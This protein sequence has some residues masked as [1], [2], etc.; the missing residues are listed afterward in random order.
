MLL[1]FLITFLLLWSPE[2]QSCEHQATNPVRGDLIIAQGQRGTSVTLG[3]KQKS[4]FPLLRLRRRGRKGEEAAFFHPFEISNPK[5][6]M[7]SLARKSVLAA[8]AC[9]PKC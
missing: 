6:E 7:I 2:P 8:D 3:N 4:T 5:P 1:L 9:P